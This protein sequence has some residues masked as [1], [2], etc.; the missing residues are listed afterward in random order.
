MTIAD[1]LSQ[2]E[3]DELKWESLPDQFVVF[4]TETTGLTP[5]KDKILEIG[6]VLFNKNDYRATGEI[7][8]FQCFIKQDYPI[9]PE[10]TEINGIT[11][12]MVK[13]GLSEYEAL[14]QFF[15]FVDDRQTYA[16]NAKFDKDF[17]I[18]TAKGSGYF[19][20]NFSLAV[21]DIYPLAKEC[22]P[23]LPNWKLKTVANQIGVLGQS[24]RAV[25]DSVMA[26]K[27]FVYIKQQLAIKANAEVIAEIEYLKEETKKLDAQIKKVEEKNKNKSCFIATATYHDIDHPNVRFL[28]WYRD[29]FLSQNKLGRLFIKFYYF[30]GPYLAY[31]VK[32][33]GLVNKITK[34]LLDKL[35]VYLTK[36]LRGS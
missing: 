9:P 12:E 8:S 1:Y 28:R 26:L 13:D 5:N 24:H 25:D 2:E 36:R 22:F 4:D 27:V 33:V 6:A 11:D 7:T 18:A 32:N 20:E 35:V 19:D 23:N 30:S 34:T 14:S 21:D 29:N 10:A 16:Y 3:L 31:P 15:E 17:I